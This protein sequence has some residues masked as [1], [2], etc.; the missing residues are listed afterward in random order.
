MALINFSGKKMKDEAK[1]EKLRGNDYTPF[2]IFEN[3]SDD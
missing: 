3:P 1:A 2:F